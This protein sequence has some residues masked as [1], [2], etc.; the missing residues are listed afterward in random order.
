MNDD[1]HNPHALATAGGGWRFLR[2]G[3]ALPADAQ[4]WAG[5]GWVACPAMHPALPAFLHTYRT[6]APDPWLH[7]C[8]P[9]VPALR[10][11]VK[12]AIQA[13]YDA[14]RDGIAS[15]MKRLLPLLNTLEHVNHFTT[16]NQ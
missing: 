7:R 2:P 4:M 9:E 15:S 14:D 8:F 10:G 13:L 12:L 16:C 3:E 1:W 5:G 11:E 6:Q